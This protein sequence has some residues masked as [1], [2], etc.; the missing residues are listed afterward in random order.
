M[1]VGPPR[2]Q[3][4]RSTDRTMADSDTT[5]REAPINVS[6]QDLIFERGGGSSKRWAIRLG[7]R[8][9]HNERPSR[10]CRIKVS[11]AADAT[12]LPG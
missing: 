7:G 8:N 12:L 9:S 5:E 1:V 10:L 11:G 3:F 6:I 2:C 4:Y